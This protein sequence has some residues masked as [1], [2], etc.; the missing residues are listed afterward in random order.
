MKITAIE[1][2]ILESPYE[3]GMADDASDSRGPKY[4]L[5][6]RVRT[7]EGIVGIADC[8]SH[9]HVMKALIDAPRYL[10]AFSEGLKY[11]VIGENPFEYD[12]IWANMYQSAFYQ[13]RRGAAIHA[14]SAIDIAIW[15]IIG[16][17]AGQPVSVMLGARNHERIKAYASTLF[18]RTPEAMKEAVRKY[19][20]LGYRAMKFGWGVVTEDPRRVVPLVAAA[21][22]EAGNDMD[23][24]VDGMWT[25]DVKLAIQLV[26]E[27]E[28]Y[29]VFFV[30][31]PLHSDN[32]E[33]YR[34]LSNAVN[35]RIACGEQLGG[36]YE[37]KQLI[38]E[39]DI[40]IIQPDV[41]RA[42]GLTETRKLV[43]MAEQAGKLIIPH[44]WTSDVLTAASLHLN[45]YQKHPL[46]QEFCTNDTPLSRDLVLEPLR[47]DADGYVA[48]PS[49]PG[50]GVA[51][52][53]A[54]VRKYSVDAL[55]V[56]V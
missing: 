32:L 27:L 2:D 50:L 23:I 36:L 47:L 31:E 11:A 49:G 41:S 17:A 20:S 37:Y 21:R 7:D 40:D 10:K 6:V 46:F 44:A 30:E 22:K 3:Y 13:G 52:D 39:A 51:L 48:V 43:T 15:D 35:A 24:M 1:L 4:A 33:G 38:A 19:R 42:G 5:L 53:E 56:T 12:K 28:Q 26:K 14:M 25:P 54:A 8:D 29:G 45:A 9:P 34:K 16:K 18:R 55:A